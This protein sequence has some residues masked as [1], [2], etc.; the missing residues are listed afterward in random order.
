MITLWLRLT[1]VSNCA[2]CLVLAGP[3]EA[4][5]ADLVAIVTMITK[6]IEKATCR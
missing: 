5:R 3:A 2:W 6:E 1:V 4:G